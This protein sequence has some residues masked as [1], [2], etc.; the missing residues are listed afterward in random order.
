PEQA[1]GLEIDARSDIFSLG[2]VLYEMITGRRPFKGVTPA[3]ALASL[4]GEKP[5]LLDEETFSLGGKLQRLIE[6]ML[7][8]DCADRFQT[9]EELRRALKELKP[10]LTAPGDYSTREFNNLSRLA[11]HLGFAGA[12]D[13]TKL[14]IAEAPARSTSSVSLFISQL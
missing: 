13:V 12:G 3:D 6:R 8:K 14:D 4:L 5:P 7:A 9:T 2:V 1:R 11:R 10:E